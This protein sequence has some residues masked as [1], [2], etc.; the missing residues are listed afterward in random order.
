MT[1]LVWNANHK[2]TY[3]YK[4]GDT[5]QING[6]S[7]SSL[8]IRVENGKLI[9]SSSLAS[10]TLTSA[11]ANISDLSQLHFVFSDG[12]E[13]HY[14]VG[15]AYVD[16]TST[17]QFYLGDSAA[18]H[19]KGNGGSDKI[20]GGDGDDYIWCA[21]VWDASKQVWTDDTRGDYLDGGLGND[22]IFGGVGDDTILGGAGN[23]SLNGGGGNDYIAGSD[24]DDSIRSGNAIDYTKPIGLQDIKGD[25]LVG[26][27]G[28]DDIHGGMGDD[29]L[30]GGEDNDIL[31]GGS[32]ADRIDGGDG[33]DNI[34]SGMSYDFVQ[35]VLVA[36]T[37]GDHLSGGSGN[38][39]IQGGLAAD[40][41]HGDTG[42]DRLSG[43]G[44]TDVI[45]GGDGDDFIYSGVIYDPL[46]KIFLADHDGDRLFGGAGKDTIEGG[47]GDDVIDGGSGDDILSGGGGADTIDG[48]DDNDRISSGLVYDPTN[49]S[50]SKDVVGDHLI[51]GGGN[52]ELFGGAGD[53]T[54]DGGSGTNLLVGG[55]G[56][57]TFI[58]SSR[59]DLIVDNSGDDTALV[60][61][62]WYKTNSWIEHWNFAEGVQKLPYWIDALNDSNLILHRASLDKGQYEK[63]VLYF[64]FANEPASFFDDIDKNQFSPFDTAQ[65]DIARKVFSYIGTVLN[66]E[67]RETLD[68]EGPNTVVLGN[69]SHVNH[70]AYATSRIIMVHNPIP[71]SIP[72]DFFAKTLLHEIGHVL[73]LKHP[74]DNP[75]GNGS[76]G[77]GPYLFG[78]EDADNWTVMSYTSSPAKA[79]FYE[80]SPFDLA[81]LQYTYGT[82]TLARSGDSTYAIDPQNANFIWD[83]S[84][85]DTVDGSSLSKPLQL[86]LEPGYWS[87]VGDKADKI[88]APGQITINFGTVIENAIGGSANDTIVGNN[89]DNNIQ[90]GAGN[91]TLTGGG[92]HDV[93]DGGNG[94]DIALFAGK[95]LNFSWQLL[96]GKVIVTDKSGTLGSDT[97][98]NIEKI[99]FDDFNINTR[100]AS[101]AQTISKANLTSLQE[102]YVAF[103]NR[104]PDADGMN[105]WITQISEGMSINQIAD[106]FYAAAVKF[107]DQTGY[108]ASMSNDDFVR[109][110]YK[111]VLGRTGNTAPPDADVHYWSQGLNDGSVSK[112]KLVSTILV[113]AHSFKGDK[114]F[115]WVP[116]LLD[117]KILVANYFAIQ[118]GLNYNTETDS[119]SM[120][121]AIASAVTPTD[122]QAA[123]KL[124]GLSM[125]ISFDGNIAV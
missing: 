18:N 23:D 3:D 19:I 26:G 80:Y 50:S 92:G 57:D 124:I 122:Y 79:N 119:I 31:Y 67:Y 9:F 62:N 98:I 49:Q 59:Y 116:D 71:H 110:V 82:P 117:N 101:N 35:Q 43:G 121:M 30:D 29:L 107:S 77:P 123:L 4:L 112:G 65:R 73:G 56:D 61:V 37:K 81:A 113:A 109:L 76:V 99:Q 58:I 54:L 125:T 108:T 16:G 89:A 38:D 64:C 95:L 53:D 69:N 41:I 12:S 5:I 105:Y 28:K 94:A 25:T 7:A 11:T 1:T 40:V 66:I 21:N 90:G 47:N 24:G 17:D 13:L 51:G 88:S 85:V 100:V 22:Q 118:N 42:K 70:G 93:L 2:Q 8:S 20:F 52:D 6:A 55:D 45:D 48:G 120:G 115:G 10:L 33:D 75:N 14:V 63:K 36:D 32:G 68:A 114:T 72:T 97:L 111:N 86:F 102:L 83:G 34:E 74:F 46:K 78:A 60:K 96:N 84:G 104:I 44:G 15:I 103:F 87:Y 27:A 106:S 91:D 39:T